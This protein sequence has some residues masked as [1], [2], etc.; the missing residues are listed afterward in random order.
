MIRTLQGDYKNILV[1]SLIQI[2]DVIFA[3]SAIA[4]I[5]EAYP[6]AKIT[7]MVKPAAAEVVRNHPFID[8]VIAF[9]Y[10]PKHLTFRKMLYYLWK[11]RSRRFDLYVSL[12]NKNRPG[13]LAYLA[14]IPVRIVPDAV[15]GSKARSPYLYTHQFPAKNHEKVHHTEILQNFVRA[16]TGL[17]SSARPVIA[18]ITA[19]NNEKADKLMEELPKRRYRIALCVRGTFPLK[20]W[21]PKNFAELIERLAERLDASFL[22]TG[23]PGDKE[24]VDQ[25]ISQ[26]KQPVANFCGR[27]SLMDL[28]A[29][30]ERQHVLITVDTGT[31]HIA[32]TTSVPVIALY[33]CTESYGFYPLTD[34]R[35]IF[36][37]QLPCKP[38]PYSVDECPNQ[39]AC[40]TVI[41][42]DEVLA[43]AI[44]Q[45][46]S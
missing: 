8:E 19:E 25:L 29:L 9:D 11:I 13:L 16:F 4:L 12:D 26:T 30:L 36:D 31:A 17:K 15:L 2:G 20:N 3:T 38:C 40:T 37:K 22:I 10:K 21:S 44:E 42:V 41:T 32:A 35:V 34:K 6:Q 46:E 28:A 14:R 7:V 43:A 33:C 23:A 1:T 24:Y 18:N 39:Q 5:H 27:T 45:L